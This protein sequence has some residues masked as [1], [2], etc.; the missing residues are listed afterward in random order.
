MSPYAKSQTLAENF[1][2]QWRVVLRQEAAIMLLH[3]V[4]RVLDG[5]ACITS[6]KQRDV[7]ESC[8]N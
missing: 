3:C 4:G 1:G 5:I 6:A 2:L 8:I 7:S